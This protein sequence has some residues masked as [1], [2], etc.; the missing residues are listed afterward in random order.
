MVGTGTVDE[1]VRRPR[2]QGHADEDRLKMIK[3]LFYSLAAGPGARA[4]LVG[5]VRYKNYFTES[6]TLA[7][8]SGLILHR[9]D[10]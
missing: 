2:P 6:K 4:W 10:S 7:R 9:I 3:R 1:T 5:A 8:V